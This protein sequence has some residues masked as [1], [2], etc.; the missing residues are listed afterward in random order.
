MADRFTRRDAEAAF[1]RLARVA[2]RLGADVGLWRLDYQPEHGGF[3]V[4]ER[5]E[6]DGVRRPFGPQR[7]SAR[8]FCDTVYFAEC[9]LRSM[10]RSR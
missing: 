2:G 4:E 5:T 10:G 7:R 1:G 6:H 9:L 8:E 3:L